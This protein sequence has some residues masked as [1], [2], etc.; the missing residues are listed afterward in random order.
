[1][2]SSRTVSL[3]LA[4]CLALAPSLAYA[5][6]APEASAP[7]ADVA[8]SDSP[9]WT[10]AAWS[11]VGAVAVSALIVGL[12]QLRLGEIDSDPEWL[13]ARASYTSYAGNICEE[14]TLSPR[15][16]GMCGDAS[17]M[18]ALWATAIGVGTASVV[19]AVTFFLLDAAGVDRDDSV[20]V[21][22]SAT[23]DRL[24]LGLDGRF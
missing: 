19:A 7:S 1:M 20:Q 23:P 16:R 18:E 2:T 6:E 22:A 8:P 14:P 24:Y 15:V 11:S 10:I 13:S 17:A 5:Q 9:T 21:T 3:T 4:A 12:T